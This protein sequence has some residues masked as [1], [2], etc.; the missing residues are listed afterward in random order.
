[1]KPL[2]VAAGL[3]VL[4][5]PGAQAQSARA[6][7]DPW[8]F[9]SH[10]EVGL[11]PTVRKLSAD[12]L[13]QHV[14][15]GGLTFAL[16]YR[17]TEMLSLEA[18][19]LGAST[20]QLNFKDQ[21]LLNEVSPSLALVLMPATRGRWQPY[22]L[23][24]IGHERFKFEDPPAPAKE[25]ESFGISHVGLGI[26]YDLTPR[27]IW[28]AE[29]N[30][31]VGSRDPS[32]GGF[33]GVTFRTRPRLR[34]PAVR[35]RD[36]V[37]VRDT[38]RLVE[39]VVVRDTV[40]LVD[41]VTVKETREVTKRL[42]GEDIILT[43]KDANFDFAKANLRPEAFPT[44]D[45]LATQLTTARAGIRIKVVGHTDA[46][47]RNEANRALGLARAKSVRDYLVAQGITA[48]RIDV[49]SGGEDHPIATNRTEAGR[50]LNRRV[51]ISRVP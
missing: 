32:F 31:Q 3:I 17:L 49:D 48:D 51:V 46:V 7:L 6:G 11:L 13:S 22:A 35:P 30:A 18:A 40:R 26:R 9:S 27:L 2:V 16:G 39:R 28:R 14:W 5:A 44:L 36:T 23:G 42:P 1:M 19:L 47:G 29:M 15:G 12:V 38:V 20:P 21:A 45:A 4:A 25:R 24:G 41:T 33:S 43:L 34:E 8:T 37:I 10:W 50:Q